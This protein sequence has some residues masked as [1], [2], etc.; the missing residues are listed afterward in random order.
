MF[1]LEFRDSFIEASLFYWE[2]TFSTVW[3]VLSRVFDEFI[4]ELVFIP[5]LTYKEV[6]TVLSVTDYKFVD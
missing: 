3:S 4:E 1:V 2:V 6:G 5:V